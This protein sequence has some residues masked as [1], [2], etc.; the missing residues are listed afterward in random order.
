VLRVSPVLGGI[1][2][3]TISPMQANKTL[4]LQGDVI[5]GGIEIKN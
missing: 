2:N 1:E 5:M 4:L 3:K